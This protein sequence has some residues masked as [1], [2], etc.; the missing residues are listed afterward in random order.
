[1]RKNEYIEFELPD[2]RKFKDFLEVFRLISESKENEDSKSEEFWLE[3]FPDYALENYYFAESDLKPEFKTADLDGEI[4]HFYTMTE[5]LVEN[6]EVEFLEC[7]R[8]ND[9]LGR[10]DFYALSYP[11]GG[12]SGM[13]M[14]LKSFGL[15]ASKIDE[16]G[17]IYNV[18]WESD[19]EFKMNKIKTV[20]NNGYNSLWQQIKKKFKK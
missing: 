3:K 15:R 5:H 20:A 19:S 16:G 7:K 18:E 13:T 17:G 4:W 9:S 12:I 2:E 1:M 14:F 10:L 6:L 11:Y 8:I